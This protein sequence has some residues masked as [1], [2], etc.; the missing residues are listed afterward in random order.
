MG[1]PTPDTPMGTSRL[2]L[3]GVSQQPPSA[4]PPS[5]PLG[6]SAHPSLGSRPRCPPGGCEGTPGCHRA[7]GTRLSPS[8]YSPAAPGS[9]PTCRGLSPCLCHLGDAG[10]AGG[11][12]GHHVSGTGCPGR[13]LGHSPTCMGGQ[14]RGP[15]GAHGSSARSP[16][17]TG[18]GRGP[19]TH[20][21][22][23]HGGVRGG[24]GVT[25][26]HQAKGSVSPRR[27]TG[28]LEWPPAASGALSGSR[29]S[30]KRR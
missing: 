6:T 8:G 19:G 15:Q 1:P 9:P 21:V 20:V 16:V 27:G 18:V 5:V 29:R 17:P 3:P 11:S 7:V 23:A 2:S 26:C 4:Q 25:R 30:V 14:C 10:A 13:L 24:P 28:G 22:T 12:S